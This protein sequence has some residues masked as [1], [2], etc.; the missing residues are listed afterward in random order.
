MEA[1]VRVHMYTY[2]WRE[3]RGGG[4]GGQ[5]DQLHHSLVPIQICCLSIIIQKL[6]IGAS[7][8]ELNTSELN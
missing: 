5:R 2:I 3:G 8:S 7:M 1:Y 4:G 6:L